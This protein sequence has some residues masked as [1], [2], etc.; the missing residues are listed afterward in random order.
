MSVSECIITSPSC[1]GKG[2]YSG[3][4]GWGVFLCSGW[5]IVENVRF[6]PNLPIVSKPQE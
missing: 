4:F 2:I 6:T 3:F 1:N 5:D